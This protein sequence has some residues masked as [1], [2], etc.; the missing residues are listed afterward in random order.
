MSPVND[1]KMSMWRAS[2]ML[3][4]MAAGSALIAS[5]GFLFKA[6]IQVRPMLAASMA[7]LVIL[8]ILLAF[9]KGARL[10]LSIPSFLLGTVVVLS[11]IWVNQT[12]Y[13]STDL[14]HEFF[15][16]NKILALGIAL[17]AP[18]ILWVG[19]T[20]I[21]AAGIAPVVQF[22]LL[23]P[24]MRQKL[25]LQEPWLTWIYIAVALALFLFR[26]KWH[27]TQLR[28]ARNEARA[29]VL[30]QFAHLLINAQHLTN[31]PLQTI[32]N[33]VAVLRARCPEQVELIA[34]LKRAL[35][36]VKE[37]MKLFSNS[38]SYIDWREM[39]LPKTVA[40]FEMR[41]NELL[42]KVKSQG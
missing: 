20:A 22:A 35:A 7:E 24:Q 42:E 11:A 41:L 34:T 21:F 30:Q 2:V 27:E 13:L 5:I 36:R 14:V 12:F 3:A 38:D 40:E 16:G 8:I 15:A 18:P 26:R 17:I 28:S 33:S 29:L 4:G 31:T 9:R 25:P 39:E 6:P 37:V 32:E 23:A 1:H 19:I 10:S